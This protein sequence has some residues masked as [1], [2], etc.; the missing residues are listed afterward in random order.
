V[1]NINTGENLLY[2]RLV[3]QWVHMHSENKGAYVGSA[4]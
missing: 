4:M 2:L 3:I 1:Q